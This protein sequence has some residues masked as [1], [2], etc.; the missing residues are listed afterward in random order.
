MATKTVADLA[1]EAISQKDQPGQHPLKLEIETRAIDEYG[2]P[3]AQDNASWEHIPAE[4]RCS[5]TANFN[6]YLDSFISVVQV[7]HRERRQM[8]QHLFQ[9]INQVL[10]PSKQAYTK[11]KYPIFQKK[12]G[13]G[14]GACSTRKRVLRVGP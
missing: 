3:E 8:L 11:R 2:A 12:L 10:Y 5:L 7:G 14:Y 4:Q 6:F 9:Q 1:N 13:Q